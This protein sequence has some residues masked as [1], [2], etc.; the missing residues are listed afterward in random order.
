MQYTVEVDN[1][2]LV[3]LGNLVVIDA[4]P[5][6]LSYVL[7]STTMNG[8]PIPDSTT[9]TPFPLDAPGYTIP[10]ILTGG[11]STFQYLCTIVAPGIITNTFSAAAYNVVASAQVTTPA[12]NN[13]NPQCFVNF[14]TAGGTVTSGYI[15]GGNIYVTLTNAA[16]NTS[17][18]TVDTASVVVQDT[19]SGDYETLTLT[20]TGANTGVFT[21]AGGLPTSTTGGLNPND[22]TLNVAAG[23]SLLINYTDPTYGS[24]STATAAIAAASQTK[25]LYLSDTNGPQS[26][27]RINPVAAADPNTAQTV[28]LVG[29]AAYQTIGVDNT[30]S[31]TSTANNYS[32]AC[33]VGTGTNRLML[34]GLSYSATNLVTNVTYGGVVLTRVTNVANTTANAA[35]PHPQSEIW[36]LLNP[37]S[38]TANLLVKLSNSTAIYLTAG[39]MTFSN[40]NQTAPFGNINKKTGHA[41]TQSVTVTSNTNSLVLAVL[42]GQAATYTIKSGQTAQWNTSP[43]TVQGCGSTKP[44]TSLATN[45]WTTTASDYY[46]ATEV[47]IN[48]A[49][50]PSITSATFTQTPAFCQNFV[51]PAGGI[52]IIT[53][54]IA[55]ISG[56]M[57]TNP[58]VTA[59][60]L[61]GTN[62]FL[63]LTNATHNSTTN[64]LAWSGTLS[65]NVTV[66][67][68]NAISYVISNG[69][70]GVTFK[71]NYGSSTNGS[72][73]A[74]PTTTVISAQNLG[75]YDAPYPGGA[76]QTAPYNGQTLYARVVV[77]D[78]FGSSDITSV[79]L[80]IDGPGTANDISTTLT[81]VNIVNDTGCTRTYEYVWQTG[82]T[83]GG[84]TITATANEG[85][86]GITSSISTALS[87]NFLDFGTPS[88]TQFTSGNNGVHTNSFAT[89]STAW[90]RVTDINRN[91]NATTYETVAVTVTSSSGDSELVTLTETGTNTGVFTGGI[92][93]TT[94]AVSINNGVLTAPQGSLIQ[95]TYTDITDSSDVSS[96]TASIPMPAG[97]GAIRVTDTLLTPSQTLVGNTVQFS[98]QVVN[99]GSTNL[100]TVTLTNSFPTSALTFVSASAAPGTIAGTNLIWNNIGPL[101]T[102][103]STNILLTFTASAS[104]SPAIDAANASGGGGV[105]GSA[106]VNV[107]ITHPAIAIT[108]TKLSPT[109]SVVSIS[110]NVVFQIVIQNT[111]S[112]VVPIIPLEDDYSAAAFQYVSATIPPDGS[113]GGIL[114]WNNIAT[115]SLAVG[116]SITNLVT[117]QVVGQGY[118][119]YNTAHADFATDVN[120]NAVPAAS[121][122]ASV[123]NAAALI[124]GSVYNDVNQSGI[125]TTN[126]IGLG[127]VTVQLYTD[128]NGDGNPSNG[129]LVQTATTESS[130]YY[131]FLNLPTNTYVVV[132]TDLPGYTSSSPVNNRIAV[133]VNSLTTFSNNYFFDYVVVAASYATIS[134]QVWFDSNQNGVHDT[135]EPGVTNA[136]VELVQDVNTNGLADLGEP[137]VASAYTDNTG[138]FT[139]QNVVPGNYVV[140]ETDFFGWASTGDSQGAN[141]NQVAVTLGSGASVTNV[142]FL[143]YTAGGGNGY[144]PPVAAPDSYPVFEN[145]TLSVSSTNGI[146]ANDFCTSGITNL[147]AILVATTTNGILT[148]NTNNGSF[149]YAPSANF[150]GT[151]TFAYKVNDGTTNS[152]VAAVT[153]TINAVNQPPSFTAGANQTVLENAGA[154]SV[155]TWATGISAGPANE[156]SQTVTFHVANN[157][158]SLF[159]APPVISSTGTLTYTPA[160]NANGSATVTVYLQDNGGTANGGID[161]SAT[162]TFTITVTAV[163][164]PPSFSLSTNN[165]AVLEDAGA[166]TNA[167]FLTNISVGPTNESSQTLAFF[168]SNNSSNL[169]TVQPAISTNGTLT[170][171]AAAT[172]NG[173]AT[174]TVY[175]QDN[176]GTANGGSDTSATNTFTITVTPVN[177][178]P[179]LAAINNQTILENAGTQTVGL[180]GISAGPPNES[181]QTL[182]ITATSGNPGLIP[183]PTIGYTNGNTTGTLIYAPTATSNGVA[184]ITV[185]V[186][187]NGGTANGGSDSVT[188]SFTVTVTPVNQPPSFVK[189]FDLSV[190]QLAGPQSI[191]NWATGIQPGPPNEAG[192]TV[193]FVVTNNANNLF[194]VQPQLSSSGM[195]T[196]TPAT[197]GNG[198]A[199]VTVV[200]HDNG[201]TANGGSD[202]SAPQTFVI[203]VGASEL[204][205]ATGGEAISAD[206]VGGAWTTLSGPT[207]IEGNSGAIGAGTI[208]LQIP[209]GFECDT[210]G[211]APTVLIQRNGGTGPDALN[212]NG[213]TNGQALAVTSVTSTQI[214]FTVT[215][216]SSNLVSDTLTFQ[217]LRVRPTNGNLPS[218]QLVTSGGTAVI[219]QVEP[220]VTSWGSLAEVPG[221]PAQLA[222]GTEPS[223][224]ATAGMAFAQ[225]PVIWVEDIY[226]N[227]VTNAS[228]T[229]TAAR[230]AG[231]GT[232]Q[233]TLTATLVNGVATFVNLYH[234]VATNITIGFSSGSLTPVTST[235][236][237]IQTASADHLVM[238]QGNNQTNTVVS[239]LPVNPAVRVVDAFGNP[240]AG[241]AVTFTVQTGGGSVGTATVASDVNG[242]AATTYTLGTAAGTGN[243][244]MQAAVSGLPGTPASLTFTESAS[245][246]TAAK[247]A[248]QT[249]P[250][251]TANAG[252]ALAQ[253]PVV[254]V[255]D[256]YGNVVANASGLTVTATRDAGS[257]TLQGGLLAGT[258]NGV[259]TFTGLYHNVATNITIVFSSGSLTPV[260]STVVA[261]SA[262]GADHLVMVQGNNQTNTVATALPVNPTVR[263][264]DAFGNP[265]SGTNVTFAVQTGG[266]SVGTATVASD[267]GGLAATTYTLGTA[268]GT[269]NNTM[270]AS[271][272]VAGN[273]NNIT[274]T[275]SAV[276]GA[277]AQLAI[278]TEPSATATAGVNFAQ[279]PVVW[280]EDAYG[281][282]VTNASGTVT[283]TR[284][285][286]SGSLQGTPVVTIVNGVATFTSLHHNVAGNITINFASG[287]FSTV[288]STV[289]SI[290]AAG[291]DHLVMIQGNNQSATVATAVSANPT[292]EVVDA[293]GNPVSGVSVGF[294]VQTGGGHV[295]TATVTSDANGLAATTYTMGTIAGTTN[296]TML[297]SATVAGTPGSIT[298]IES[299]LV[300]TASK[301]AIV[302]E[303]STN[304]TAG[305]AFAQQPVVWVE[306]AYGNLVTSAAG[307]VTA[308]RDAGSGTLQGTLTVTVVNGVA[309]YTDLNHTVATNITIDFNSGALA[310]VTSTA[311]AITAAAADHLDMVTGDGQTG[312]INKPLPVNPTVRV[313]DQFENPVPGSTVTFSVTTTGMSGGKNGSVSPTSATSDTNGLASTTYTLGGD[314]GTANNTMIATNAD[315]GDVYTFTESGATTGLPVAD[316][317]TTVTGPSVVAI[318][319]QITYQITTLNTGPSNAANVVVTDLLPAGVTGVTAPGGTI[320]SGQVTWTIATLTNGVSSNLTVTVTA[321]GTVGSLSDTVSS[322]SDTYDPQTGNND[323]SSA[324]A[325]V[326]TLVQSADV[327]TTV[328]GPASTTAGTNFIYTILVTNQGPSTAAGVILTNI[329]PAG[330]TIADASGGT[331]NGN[332]VTWNVG[333]LA[334]GGWNSFTL[335]LTPPTT[336]GT[337]TNTVASTAATY[338]P[339]ATNNNG[340]AVGGFVITV[341]APLNVAP[342]INA[343]SNPTINENAGQQTV[344]LAGITAGGGASQALTVTATS[345]NPGLIPNPTVNYTSP[346]AT[347]TLTFT[348]AANAFGTATVTVVVHD[349]GGT[350][351]GGVDSVTNTFTVTVNFVNQPPNFTAGANQTVLENAAA[352][353]V[354]NWATA[355][356]A[357]PANESGQTVTFHVANNNSSLFSAQPA[358]SSTGTLTYTPATNANGSATVTVYLQDNG[359]TANGGIDTSA[360]NTFT[361]TVTPVNQPPSFSLLTNNVAVLENG[362]AQNLP[363]AANISAG[364]ANESSQ[365]VAFLVGNNN[366]NSLFSVQ[367]AISA[368]GTLTFTPAANANGTATVTVYA[369]DNGGTA[370]GGVDTSAAQTFAITVTPVNQPPTLNAISDL[371]TNENSGLQTVNLSGITPGPANESSQT[372]TITAASS[373][374]SVVPNPTVNYTSPDATGTL[375]FTPVT[376]AFG[377]ATV[378]VIAHDNGGTANGGVDSVTNTFAVTIN[379]VNQPPS[380]TA[381]GNQTVLE[382]AGAQTVANWATSISAGPANESGQTVTF[383]V[384]NNDN[385]LFS[386]QPAISA[387]GTLTYTPAT[388]A[389]GSATV[390]VYAQDNGGTANGGHDTSAT[391]TFTINVTPIN[392]PPTL[393]PIS[394]LTITEAAGLQTVNLG[395]ITAGPA[396]ESGQT[397]TVTATSGNPSLIPDPTV[398]Y[399]NPAATGTLTFTS[400]SNIL[401][402][403]TITVIVQDNG[404]T[405]NGGVDSVTNTFNVTVLALTNIWSPGGGFTVNV[406]DATGPAGTGY[407]QTNYTGYLDVQATST[408]PF[409]IQ[410]GSLN[411]GSPGPA[412]DFNNNSNYTWTIA[413]TTRGVLEFDPAKIIVDTSAFTNDLAGGTFSVTANGDAV[414]LVFAPNHPPVASQLYLSRAWG[415]VMRIPIAFVLTNSTTDPDGDPTALLG[416]GASTNGTP[417]TTNASYIFFTPT[418]NL[419]ESFTYTVRDVRSYR[420]GDT[421]R[422]ATSWITI[423]VTNAIGPVVSVDS[424]GG[425]VTIKFAG[426][427]GYAYDV[428]RATDL[429][430]SWTVVLTTNAPPHG[431][432]IYTDSNPPQP[433]AF[434]RLRQH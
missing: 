59:T 61:N 219:Q 377:T 34:V 378:T 205:R 131:E 44:G 350:A 295:G 38:G 189:G 256:Q 268:A 332:I 392:Q 329:V 82:A 46:A 285:A 117:M 93:L 361:I 64:L 162:N 403:T 334:S 3:P 177:H 233:G 241:A 364:P 5:T 309:A 15:V 224:T 92:V 19:T 343:I 45:T 227:I 335:T 22:G 417:I 390:T 74:L 429:G 11:T 408:N 217:N 427:P 137:V 20:E 91:T 18:N 362:G 152:G 168:V 121:S 174:V 321:P 32:L 210:G 207:Y 313:V 220:G 171:A 326:V 40:V 298:F 273:P 307:T 163:N 255:E 159:S 105:T 6:N 317:V 191:T 283:A 340:T 114:M 291:A 222:I 396:N 138:L 77:S 154:Q 193:S 414:S 434:Y 279:Q 289:V 78:P 113:G 230:N 419:S 413:T 104:A 254:L 341:V 257:G 387:T 299:A 8:N 344:N 209:A 331:I 167:N 277:A 124:S 393:N 360:T 266:G 84:Y 366:N 151:D 53:N 1:K 155:A 235:M 180:N 333:S 4:P 58:A 422:T 248:I 165:V 106:S 388:N 290:N 126:D 166:Q 357:G 120:G 352:Q 195:L 264:V 394:D 385:G 274:F 123:T 30:T 81:N 281:N 48:P 14:T 386:V 21:I 16:A 125:L 28:A 397:L 243:N 249:E 312:A 62:V 252:V 98:I 365:T 276:A 87:L 411:G 188:N 423:S 178:A 89:N 25:V 39:A 381:G 175:A 389:S 75:I 153:I 71:V 55:I 147:T 182:T 258:V 223:A 67:A 54:W 379:A 367:P 368:S 102:G 76:L 398:N 85:T 101:A 150:F 304:A 158:S 42:A 31:G 122:T 253:Q 212:I 231:S 424:S 400:V 72:K 127:G 179:T 294:A 9:G 119:A 97:T 172:S 86:E 318:N 83:V 292:I 36:S 376:N 225:Q 284:N 130:G 430:G 244:T 145:K 250:S 311:I 421:V 261:I 402:T 199:T 353:T 24:S 49:I 305:V 358:I 181:S 433:S 354:A 192:Q 238:V 275:A 17:S 141:D 140:R 369:Q 149:T 160:V 169:F 65:S 142:W 202:T 391:N 80:V 348:P 237:S 156:S 148:L 198:Q 325:T 282:L 371:T 415:T 2:G 280:V 351:N 29:Q 197:N 118:P 239:A 161:T 359:G 399:L 355:I 184:T 271:A 320:S 164:Q 112:T 300:G 211:V 286:G 10:V 116:A 323:G 425:T 316:V 70:A 287:G 246:G 194:T 41:K 314:V 262:A 278:H 183:N 206:T 303:P 200:A 132:E 52:I 265:V 51:M 56:T 216:A 372:V 234:N 260:T 247:L 404:G 251:A 33:T 88:M 236:V 330:L 107:T 409:T 35:N 328:T 374:P 342:T 115:N 315:S 95:V 382:N 173:V 218:G 302:T 267:A 68:G 66:A 69:Q 136:F 157:N 187:D 232:L 135:G 170:F 37:P 407:T 431:L 322:T 186:Q 410:L 380:F 259:A 293:F 90:I 324:G 297:A 229:V 47:S 128:P 346:N 57:P 50:A 96:D 99:T 221:S 272:A 336:G 370:N 203:S 412:A 214:V 383:H 319:G 395:G 347:G 196:F 94:N 296:N 339:V 26:L 215:S 103:Q 418:N 73:I 310:P 143:D 108:K 405:A 60:L 338:D 79:G 401:G 43:G 375:T 129:V 384:S 7:G 201:G 204:I 349:N 176:G 13:P 269:G 110:S 134:G 213:A 406:S 190:F 245:P 139:F 27:N 263:V 428:E 100:P 133:N 345:S 363:L 337:F 288:T 146:F 242:L 240:V 327:Q 63:V 109:N 270:T 356:S 23:D 416:L 12:T 226:G 185:V 301:L 432:W 308:V 228:G 306:D 208:V 111:G 420:P 144:Y 426:V 373:N